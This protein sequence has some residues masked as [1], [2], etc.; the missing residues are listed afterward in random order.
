MRRQGMGIVRM[1]CTWN[2]AGINSSGTETASPSLG[3]RCG[4]CRA[5]SR[6]DQVDVM[7]VRHLFRV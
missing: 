2:V 6:L 7:G 3:A 5:A 1:H 4:L